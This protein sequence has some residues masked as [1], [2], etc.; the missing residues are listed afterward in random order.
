[1]IPPQEHQ[2]VRDCVM[3]RSLVKTSGANFVQR[4]VSLLPNTVLFQLF[5]LEIN[6][7]TPEEVVSD[8]IKQ[9]FYL[10]LFIF[11]S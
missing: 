5:Q 9:L 6:V 8:V 1:M 4:G 2:F 10:L 3:F 11:F 7:I